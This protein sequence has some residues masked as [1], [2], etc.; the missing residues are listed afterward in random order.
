M[1]STK[2]KNKSSNVL[3]IYLSSSDII[4][5][6]SINAPSFNIELLNQ[7]NFWDRERPLYFMVENLLYPNNATYPIIGLCWTN[8]P[9]INRQI[10]TSNSSH[11]GLVFIRQNV[12]STQV[13]HRDSIG[14]PLTI[15]S[16][17]GLSP[18]VFNL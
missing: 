5:G 8:M 13:L 12:N 10:V 6:S 4:V 15:E 2:Q 18:L 11:N 9:M 16:L 1:L 14:Y 3:R 7:L 17:L